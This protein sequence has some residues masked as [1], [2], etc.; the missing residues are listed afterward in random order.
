MLTSDI[1]EKLTQGINKF[2]YDKYDLKKL[3]DKYWK[4]FN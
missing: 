1:I 3:S 2:S 4:Y